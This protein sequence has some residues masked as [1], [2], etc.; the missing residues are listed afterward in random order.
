MYG[1]LKKIGI[2]DFL[3]RGTNDKENAYVGLYSRSAVLE[4]AISI[5]DKFSQ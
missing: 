1:F 2:D 4:K 3:L 5:F